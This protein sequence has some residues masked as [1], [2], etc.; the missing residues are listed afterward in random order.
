MKNNNVLIAVASVVTF[1]FATTLFF[2]FYLVEKI[3]DNVIEKL[4]RDY[5]PGPY[6]PGFDPYKVDPNIFR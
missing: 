1:L 4:K 3:T 5:A 6:D 2:N